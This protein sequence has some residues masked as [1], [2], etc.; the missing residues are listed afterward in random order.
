MDQGSIIAMGTPAV[1]KKEMHSFQIL[2][3]VTSDLLETMKAVEKLDDVH[4]AAVF[5]SGL[6]VTVQNPSVSTQKIHQILEQRKIDILR[7]EVVPPT[8]ED[9]FVA[10]VE[11][12]DHREPSDRGK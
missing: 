1:L 2:D 4:D 8:M 12:G 9:V 5:G 10:M 11:N 7:L 6:H 3:L